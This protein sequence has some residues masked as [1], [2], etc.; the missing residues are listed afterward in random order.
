MKSDRIVKMP[1]LL[2]R[3]KSVLGA[4][5]MFI[6][7]PLDT[8]KTNMQNQ[9]MRF[10]QAAR[11]LFKTEGVNAEN[12][13]SFSSKSNL[14]FQSIDK[15]LLSWPFISVVLNRLFK[16]DHFWRLRQF[17]SNISEY[18]IDSLH[19]RINAAFIFE[20]FT[21]TNLISAQDVE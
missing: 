4:C 10:V 16:F 2:I 18:V 11:I 9:N 3:F 7:H 13:L 21:N 20:Y 17:I 5:N 19:N 14:Q 1:L 12:Q 8:V 15:I 6:S